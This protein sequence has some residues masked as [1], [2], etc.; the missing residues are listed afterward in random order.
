MRENVG[1]LRAYF[2]LVGLWSGWVNGHACADCVKTMAQPMP[3]IAR[4]IVGGMGVLSALQTL[5]AIAYVLVAIL[6]VSL[7]RNGGALVQAVVVASLACTMLIAPFSLLMTRFSIGAFVQLG[8]ALV[9]YGYL[10]FQVRRL[11]FQR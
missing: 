2:G 8:L 10:L 4:V 9:V 11:S 1:S 5:V 3:Q 7:L 6:L